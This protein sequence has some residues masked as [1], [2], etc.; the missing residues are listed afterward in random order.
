M[1]QEDS[2]CLRLEEASPNLVYLK[3][4]QSVTDSRSIP[5]GNQIFQPSNLLT[6][7]LKQTAIMEPLITDYFRCLCLS[8]HRAPIK[9]QD[10]K[11]AKSELI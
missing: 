8:E 6:D 1:L 9:D 11:R 7:Y 2:G 5:Q 4:I 10:A 3:T